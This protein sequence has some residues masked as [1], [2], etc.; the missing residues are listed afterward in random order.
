MF[1]GLYSAVY[2]APVCQIQEICVQFAWGHW[3]IPGFSGIDD[4]YKWC[5]AYGI[6]LVVEMTFISMIITFVAYRPKD[7]RLWSYSEGF[8]QKHGYKN[9]MKDE[10][11]LFGASGIIDNV[12]ESVP[13]QA[14]VADL[15][16]EK[17]MDSR[18]MS[19]RFSINGPGMVDLRRSNNKKQPLMKYDR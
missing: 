11:F 9:T 14:Y 12:E 17:S 10:E 4:T 2:I 19:K 3:A 1:L 6:I 16:I 7:L 13:D 5:C 15:S 8:L 18:I